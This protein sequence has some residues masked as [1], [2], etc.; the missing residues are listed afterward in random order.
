MD[1]IQIFSFQ[2]GLFGYY[3][4]KKSVGCYCSLVVSGHEVQVLPCPPL[5]TSGAP[6]TLWVNMG[7]GSAVASLIA[8]WM[9]GMDV[10]HDC[11]RLS[12]TDTSVGCPCC[13]GLVLLQVLGG[14]P[15]SILC[16]QHGGARDREVLRIDHETWMSAPHVLPPGGVKSQFY[17]GLF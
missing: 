13:H 10:S 15:L 12:S 1:L 8:F 14:Y 11:Y 2:A 4:S 9:G 17:L 6:F 5:F 3:S 16:A 7:S